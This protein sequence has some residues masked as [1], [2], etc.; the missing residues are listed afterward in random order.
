MRALQGL[1]ALI[2]VTRL[3]AECA[4]ACSGNGECGE[5]DQCFCY[6]GYQANDCSER[7]CYFGLAHVDSPK[8]DLNGDGYVNGPLTTVLTGSEVYPWGTTEQYPNADANE[9]HFYME[10]SNR[11][12]CNRDTGVCECFDGYDGTACVRKACPEDC[13]GHGTCETIKELSEWKGY[14]TRISHSPI[15]APLGAHNF[16]SAIEESYAYDLWD[17]DKSTGCKCD[18]G[19]FGADCSLRKCAYGVDPIF[20]SK[21][22][23]VI[24]QTAVIHLGSKGDRRGQ[25]E[26]SFN[27]IFYDAFGEKFVTKEIGVSGSSAS[28]K[29]VREALQALPDGVISVASTDLG[30]EAP[31]AVQVAYQAEGGGI[32]D[33][34]GA[35]GNGG[36]GAG[37]FSATTGAGLGTEMSDAGGKLGHEFTITFNSNPG[38]L[39]AI[40]IDTRQLTAPGNPDYWTAQQRAGQFSTRYSTLIDKVVACMYGSTKLYAS[41]DMSGWMPAG[42]LVKVGGQELRVEAINEHVVTFGEPYLG[43]NIMPALSDTGLTA[44]ALDSAGDTLTIS[45]VGDWRIAQAI[46]AGAKLYA[47][48]CPFI[49]ADVVVTSGSTSIEI[50]NDHDC[51]PD[52]FTGGVPLYTMQSLDGLMGEEVESGQDI[53]ITPGDTCAETQQLMLQRGSADVYVVEPLVDHLSAQV[54]AT[55]FN[56]NT[57]TFTIGSIGTTT[58]PD[59]TSVFVNG[60]GPYTVN[61]QIANNGVAMIVHNNE[62]SK[63]FMGASSSTPTTSVGS[64][65]G[66]T[67]VNYPIHKVVSDV[68]GI[69]AGT[70]KLAVGG[71]RYTINEKRSTG[72]TGTTANSHFVLGDV[73]THGLVRVCSKCVTAVNAAGSSVTLSKKVTLALGEQILIGGYVNDDLAMTVT[74]AVTNAASITTS[75]G[76]KN[77]KIATP[78][79]LSGLVSDDTAKD[80]YK[81]MNGFGYTGAYC[82]EDSTGATFQHVSQCSNRGYCQTDSG[83]CK[84]YAGYTNDNCDTQNAVTL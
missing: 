69:T 51:Q 48:G 6:N 13:S 67:S 81:K 18:P 41:N 65:G 27:I 50:E 58:V 14:D 82:T 66:I 47:G 68:N 32:E 21:M 20:Y 84:C 22:D 60:Q 29:K 63:D 15:V 2:G 61:G 49:S 3:R 77:G 16:D 4:N 36:T 38:L 5:R 79:T 62:A 34:A 39:K 73:F 75:P 17:A 80:L 9:G 37:S 40:E 24:Y 64:F 19:Y 59:G 55:A 43:Q 23:G 26:G 72:K 33:P 1:V 78:A 45:S 71:R 30:L 42:T 70:H 35:N 44:S 74:A 76:C 7:T 56:A 8:G 11:G 46:Q 53:Y 10:C 57:K 54:F 31:P 12:L 25:V 83:I 28:A 52:I